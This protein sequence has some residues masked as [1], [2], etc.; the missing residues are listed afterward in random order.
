MTTAPMCAWGAGWCQTV[1]WKTLHG[2]IKVWNQYQQ[3]VK[4]RGL[5]KVSLWYCKGFK[6]RNLDLLFSFCSLMQILKEHLF[7]EWGG[8][9]NYITFVF[10]L[11]VISHFLFAWSH[12]GCKWRQIFALIG[13]VL[14]EE[15][16]FSF[17]FFFLC[18]ADLYFNNNNTREK[19]F[20]FLFFSFCS[21][22][23]L[24]QKK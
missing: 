8:K 4:K 3:R 5:R 9:V 24:Y 18:K 12:I 16:T 22:V 2:W 15:N 21:F 6:W 14:N 19:P 10:F 20:F 1:V 17:F 13:Q 23:T 7:S 11:Q